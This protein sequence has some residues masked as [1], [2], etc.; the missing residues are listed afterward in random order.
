MQ[1]TI[2]DTLYYLKLI[3]VY[4]SVSLFFHLIIKNQKISCLYKKIKLTFKFFNHI[5]RFKAPALDSNWA[6]PICKASFKINYI[7]TNKREI[8]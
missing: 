6:A 8:H 1:D 3:R 2:R 7:R 5:F 4:I